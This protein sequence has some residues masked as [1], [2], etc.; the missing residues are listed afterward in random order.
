M[1]FDQYL[2]L[3]PFLFT[4]NFENGLVVQSILG[5]V[6]RYRL[7]SS[8]LPQRLSCTL[9]IFPGNLPYCEPHYLLLHASL[10]FLFVIMSVKGAIFLGFL[11]FLG[12][13]SLVDIMTVFAVS[14]NADEMYR[15]TI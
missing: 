14:V 4:Y 3:R 9:T 15:T 8:L 5:F 1:N 13:F 12:L 2:P 7:V 11:D 6:G 10:F